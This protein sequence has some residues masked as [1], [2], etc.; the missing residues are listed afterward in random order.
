MTYTEQFNEYFAKHQDYFT[1]TVIL[2]LE[3]DEDTRSE[4]QA[5]W[6]KC[7]AE[8]LQRKRQ[9]LILFSH[10]HLDAITLAELILEEQKNGGNH[11]KDS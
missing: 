4:T 9:D 11:E 3:A 8:N 1:T 10:K 6:L 7:H 5:H 2:Y